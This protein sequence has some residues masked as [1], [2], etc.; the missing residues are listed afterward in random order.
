VFKHAQMN[1]VAK[2]TFLGRKCVF[3]VKTRF[4]VENRFICCEKMRQT[5]FTLQMSN[6]KQANIME[7][8]HNN[9]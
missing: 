4:K 6:K 1:P 9:H 7:H 2:I 8:D 5:I 3:L